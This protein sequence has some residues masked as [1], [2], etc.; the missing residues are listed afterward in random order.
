MSE[1]IFK[2]W[3]MFEPIFRISKDYSN[4]QRSKKQ[5]YDFL[6][7]ILEAHERDYQQGTKSV[8]Q[9]ARPLLDRLY[10]LR[11]TM[12]YEQTRES[13]F[14]FLAAGFETTGK[15]IPCAVLLLAMN[16]E[17]QDKVVDEVRS[18]LTKD[19]DLSEESLNKMTYLDLVI[20]ESLRL[21]PSP[22]IIGRMVKQDIKLSKDLHWFKDDDYDEI[23]ISAN[24]T[25][26]SGT[27]LGFLPLELHTVEKYWGSDAL[28]FHPERF[29]ESNSENIN[30]NAYIPFS[31]GPRICPGYKY[32]C[33]GMK[34]F[35]CKFLL[36]YRITTDLK[37]ED[38]TIDL[39]ATIKIKQGIMVRAE[40]R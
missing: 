7:N 15:A 38:L 5:C 33:M 25:V 18:I 8:G 24:Y 21:L 29:L 32:A 23:L 39:S 36:S 26:P 34:S 20:K 37:Y 10:E 22:I 11:H 27:L 14:L 12:T 16:Q 17:C 4:Y 1:K 6:D 3:L 35:L 9:K 30:L 19:E 2:I 31:K 13:A 40:R 28:E